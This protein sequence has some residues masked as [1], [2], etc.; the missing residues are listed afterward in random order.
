MVSETFLASLQSI[1]FLRSS[2]SNLEK[3]FRITCRCLGD[4]WLPF[5]IAK[6]VSPAI[7][8]AKNSKKTATPVSI[9]EKTFI[10]IPWSLWN[11]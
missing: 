2:E 6:T 1:A 3:A 10:S 11:I 7:A 4:S 8:E 5:F 9:P